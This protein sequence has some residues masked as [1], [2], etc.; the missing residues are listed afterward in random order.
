MTPLYL[1]HSASF[2]CIPELLPTTRYNRSLYAGINSS[3]HTTIHTDSSYC[4]KIAVYA[5]ITIEQGS[6]V[7]MSKR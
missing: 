5:K 7:L 2:Y 1:V 4:S 6:L 3:C